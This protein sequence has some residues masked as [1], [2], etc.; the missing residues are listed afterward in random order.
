MLPCFLVNS[1]AV[2]VSPLLLTDWAIRAVEFP[3][4]HIGGP[5]LELDPT[6]LDEFEQI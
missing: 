4:T 1:G 2:K 5:E 6:D 3:L